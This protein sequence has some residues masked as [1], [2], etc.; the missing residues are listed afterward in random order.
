MV[1]HPY[2]LPGDRP[3]ARAVDIGVGG[4][5]TTPP[6]WGHILYISYVKTKV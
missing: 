4:G 6:F 2:M 3:Q 1:P 5:R